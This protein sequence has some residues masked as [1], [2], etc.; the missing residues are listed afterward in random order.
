MNTLRE[1]FFCSISSG[2]QENSFEKF[3]SWPTLFLSGTLDIFVQFK[4]LKIILLI[5]VFSSC[6]KSY[7]AH[8][9][10]WEFAAKLK[11]YY[12]SVVVLG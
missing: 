1:I 3:D 4:I 10:L 5:V 11:I 7:F 6:K 12:E 2:F 9:H 8:I